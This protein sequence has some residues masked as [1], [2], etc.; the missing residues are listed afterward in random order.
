ML[1]VA[2]EQYAAEI[3]SWKRAVQELLEP[4]EAYDRAL[5]S[6]IGLRLQKRLTTEQAKVVSRCNSH[7]CVISLAF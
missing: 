4:L 3:T 1:L 7:H 2:I 6:P 5:R